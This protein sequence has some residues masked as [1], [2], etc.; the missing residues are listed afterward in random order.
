MVND[1]DHADP[2]ELQSLQLYFNEYRQQA[3][4][5]AQQLSLLEE[6][7]VEAHAAIDALREVQESPDSVVLLQIGGGASVRARLVNPD[8]VLLNIGSDV[9][10]EKSNPAAVDYL[11]DRITEMEASAKKVAETLDRIRGQMNEIGRR[12]ELLYQQVQMQP[13]PRMPSSPI[14]QVDEE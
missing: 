3:E 13:E 4:L 9:I 2:R 12:I 14:K 6:G 5:F 10:V 7:R 11:K 1:V 8:Q